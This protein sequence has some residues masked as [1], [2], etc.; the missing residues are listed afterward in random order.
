MNRPA[1][2]RAVGARRAAACRRLPK[3][4]DREVIERNGRELAAEMGVSFDTWLGWRRVVLGAPESDWPYLLMPRWSGRLRR[5][6]PTEAW[7]FFR[8]L[9][10]TR[11]QPTVTDCCRRTCEA[12]AEHGWGDLP[13]VKTFQRRVKAEIS[14][15]ELVLKRHGPE[16]LARLFPS[17]R[18]DR[19]MFAAGQAASGDGL[20]FDRLWVEFEDGEVLNT[21]TGWFWQDIA[22]DFVAA[23]RVAKTETTDLFRLATL[24]LCDI[25]VP[26]DAWVDNTR[27]AASKVMTG[28]QEGRR[29]RGRATPDDPPGL[30]T[31]LGIRVHHTNP[32]PVMGNPGSKPIERAFGIGG[33]HEAVATH[34][35]FRDRG[36][37]RKTAI[38]ISEFREVLA[39]EV[40]RFNARPGRRTAVCR[41]KLSFRQAWER[42]ITAASLRVLTEEQRAL[43]LRIP[44]TVLADRRTGEIR[45]K[46]GRGPLGRR[47]YWHEDLTSWRATKVVA[48]YDPEDF[49]AAI[50][51]TTLDGRHICRA[52]CL[53]DVGFADKTAAGEWSRNKSRFVKATRAAAAAQERMTAAETAALY[54]A[55]KETPP[56]PKPGVVRGTF[57]RTAELN[58][59]DEAVEATGTDGAPASLDGRVESLR[60]GLEE[61]LAAAALAPTAPEEWED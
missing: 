20:K 26:D 31:Q 22:T 32:D 18:R 53:E 35:R 24:D 36:Q 13:S 10:L 51:V 17:Q 45:L 14:A 46:A 21:V 54:P 6:I 39:E 55:P 28:R 41:G 27:V 15:R 25:A 7:E 47:R 56:P 29:Y 16:A 12:A 38:P 37:N 57:R 44:E 33:I 52:E 43:L 50:A 9:Y 34:P 19:R 5:E 23:H 60:R 3:W 58:P 2:H 30:L 11:R 61:R 59:R 40:E 42:G 8:S 48:W 4:A 1:R 49:S